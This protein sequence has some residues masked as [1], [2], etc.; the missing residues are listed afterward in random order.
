MLEFP[1]RCFPW[2][3]GDINK[4]LLEDTEVIDFPKMEGATL[5]P[6]TF[7]IGGISMGLMINKAS[8]EDSAKQAALVDFAD[9]LVSDE[10]FTALGEAS[11]MPAKKVAL[12]PA[13][14]NPLF[15][16]AVDFTSKQDVYDV[17]WNYFGGATSQQAY[18]DAM[19]TLWAGAPA[20]EVMT[21]L[22]IAVEQK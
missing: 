10:M 22:Q 18:S 19:D 17:A 8:F 6:A 5:D 21:K 12:D 9:F 16:T 20:L 13:Q 2:K 4:A 1:I 15:V 11:M 3:I 7:T 14:L